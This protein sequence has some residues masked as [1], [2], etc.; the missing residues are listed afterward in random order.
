MGNTR[1]IGDVAKD[2]VDLSFWA[3]TPLVLFVQGAND[4]VSGVPKDLAFLGKFLEKSPEKAELI[5][6]I[7]LCHQIICGG[8]LSI[9][10]IKR[11]RKLVTSLYFLDT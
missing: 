8:F 4:N 9:L 1:N 2:V 6:P 11:P 10:I 3:L 7:G 5:D